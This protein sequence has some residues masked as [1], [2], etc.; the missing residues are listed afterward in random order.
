MLI[1]KSNVERFFA[2]GQE[3]VTADE[4]KTHLLTAIIG[5]DGPNTDAAQK[6]A[7]LIMLNKDAILSVLSDEPKLRKRAKRKAKVT[8]PAASEN[9]PTSFKQ[10]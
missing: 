1:E 7:T 9:P 2:N 6:I 3:F 4:A 5:G 8:P 10:P